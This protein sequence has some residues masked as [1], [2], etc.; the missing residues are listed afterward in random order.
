M[1]PNKMSKDAIK[2]V[3]T[4]LEYGIF[5]TINRILDP[6]FTAECCICYTEGYSNKNESLDTMKLSKVLKM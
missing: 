2:E 5:L 1:Q 4:P 3:I 6:E